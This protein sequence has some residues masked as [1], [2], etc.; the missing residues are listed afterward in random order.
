ME[1][2]VRFGLQIYIIEKIR[3]VFDGFFVINIVE[4]RRATSLQAID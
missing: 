3:Q 2:Y 1:K 4:T